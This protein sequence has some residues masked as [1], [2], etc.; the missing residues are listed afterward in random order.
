MFFGELQC[1]QRVVI[2]SV[3]N[4]LTYIKRL[5]TI[6]NVNVEAIANPSSIIKDTLMNS[7]ERFRQTAR[8]I[9]W[10]N[11]T[12]HGQSTLFTTIR[13]LECTILRITQQLD[14]L[15]NAVQHATLG[16][17]PMT[18][19]NPV[20]L[21]SILKNISLRLPDGYE[22][23]AGT[24]FENV[25]L[26]Y[27]CLQTAFIGDPHHIKMILS[28]TL[29]TVNRHFLLYKI[30]YLPWRISNSTFIQYLPDF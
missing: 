28:V 6:T 24:K 8:D 30:L 23:A 2:H 1:S 25:H 12:I 15:M 17:L 14:E 20:T 19:V 13:E 16:N 7:H 29:K 18:L 10:L 11:L 9:I 4:Q 21:H 3:T 26:Y 27:D 5:D 22:L